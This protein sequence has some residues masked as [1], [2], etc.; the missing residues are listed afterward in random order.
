MDAKIKLGILVAPSGRRTQ[1]EG[2]ELRALANP[3]LPHFGGYTVVGSPYG[4][5]PC[6][7]F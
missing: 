2:G 5:P 4:C 3:T 6:W 7:P 1:S